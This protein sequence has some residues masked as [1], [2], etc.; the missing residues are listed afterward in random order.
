MTDLIKKIT[1]GVVGLGLLT[2]VSLPL[3]AQKHETDYFEKTNLNHC[4]SGKS[5]KHNSYY[6]KKE[7]PDNYCI[8][9]A[10]SKN[11]KKEFKREKEENYCV[12]NQEKR[13]D[14]YLKREKNRER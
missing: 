13:Y 14:T 10:A 7:K 5:I 8:S 1:A 12:G 2:L 4:I 11:K 6:F 9:K 3:N